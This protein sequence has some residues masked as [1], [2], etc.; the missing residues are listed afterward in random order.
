MTPQDYAAFLES[1]K[2]NNDGARKDFPDWLKRADEYSAV[3]LSDHATIYNIRT[4]NG[5]STPEKAA[6]VVEYL[7]ERL[8]RAESNAKPSDVAEQVKRAVREGMDA[9]KEIT[10]VNLSIGQLATRHAVIRE[11]RRLSEAATEKKI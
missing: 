1:L 6:L 2:V 5:Y 10:N 9:Q 4:C 3:K 7:L 11:F 8:R